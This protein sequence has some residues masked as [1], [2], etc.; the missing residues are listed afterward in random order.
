VTVLGRD[1][2][3]TSRPESNDR[4]DDHTLRLGR[5]RARDGTTGGVV[6]L[7][8]DRP[9]AGLVVGKRG[10]GKS[11]TLGVLAEGVAAAVGV[12][13]VILDTMGE[14]A[15]VAAAGSG[16][17]V[18]DQPQVRATDL[19]PRAWPELVGLDPT[20]A[21]GGLVW[22]LA[23]ENETL[24]EMIAAVQRQCGDRPD[25]SDANGLDV[26]DAVRRVVV[27]HLR[28]ARRWGVFDSDGLALDELFTDGAA[29]VLDC[30]GL[31]PPATNAVCRVLARRCYERCLDDSAARLPWLFVDEAHVCFDGIAAPALERL[32]T[33]GRTPGVSVVC[34]TQRPA[35]LPAVPISQSGL[36][37]AHALTSEADIARLAE[38]RPTYLTEAFRAQLPSERGTALVVD[39]TDERAHTVR[40]R[41]RRTEHGGATPRASRTTASDG[42]VE[43]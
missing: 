12:T 20:G 40:V 35:A 13:P 18:H 32:Y 14:F 4:R 36:V 26:S 41:E 43:S 1:T 25:V 23:A 3:R 22:Q 6:R 38:T 33:Q 10:T 16:G 2:D 7:D 27:N 15:G 24:A 28:R 31:S 9:H 21:A 39:D 34:A 29:T 30:S 42:D 5:H 8:T 19:P 17:I 11:H 37:V